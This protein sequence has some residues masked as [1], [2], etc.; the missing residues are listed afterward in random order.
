MSRFTTRIALPFTLGGAI[1]AN[2]LGGML[3]AGSEQWLVAPGTSGF[4]TY[5]FWGGG[6]GDSVNFTHNLT[7]GMDAGQ[8]SIIVTGQTT[9]TVTIASNTVQE[10]SLDRDQWIAT[11]TVDPSFSGAVQVQAMSSG[12]AVGSAGMDYT[13]GYDTHPNT[14]PLWWASLSDTLSGS[15]NAFAIFHMGGRDPVAGSSPQSGPVNWALNG[16]QT[17]FNLIDTASMTLLPG[18]QAMVS[19][20][21]FLDFSVFLRPAN[22]ATF[23]TPGTYTFIMDLPASG[24]L[25]PVPEPATIGCL[26]GGSLIAVS[27]RRRRPGR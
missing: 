18:H 13:A 25:V 7:L 22:G 3:V 17:N 8:N 2:V 11:A 20:D 26:L 27:R 15:A 6:A 1:S 24:G 5:H 4:S 23:F 10:V 19:L 9:Y 14:G 16:A 12:F 21:T